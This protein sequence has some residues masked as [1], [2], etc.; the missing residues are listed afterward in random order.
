MPTRSRAGK[1]LD[2]RNLVLVD[3]TCTEINLTLW[4]DMAKADGS[5]WEGNPVVAFKGV[6]LS[7]FNGRSLNSLNASTLVNDP[8]VPE[9]ADL[10]A[11]FDAAGG[12]SSFKSVTVR[13]GGGG[14]KVAKKDM[15]QRY[16]LQSITDGNLGNGEKPD[17]A[18]VKATISFIK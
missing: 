16:T 10:R 6:K 9:T 11:W 13:N 15:S 7:D 17:W 5:R 14:G 1:Q 12:G 4:G 3:D 8:D 18:V 2:K